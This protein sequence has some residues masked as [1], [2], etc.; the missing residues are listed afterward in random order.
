MTD[1]S[2]Y[3]RDKS[4]WTIKQAREDDPAYWSW[5]THTTSPDV[6]IKPF[7]DIELPAFGTIFMQPPEEAR[8]EAESLGIEPVYTVHIDGTLVLRCPGHD[9]VRYEGLELGYKA[10]SKISFDRNKPEHEELLYE[11]KHELPGGVI[12]RE[13]R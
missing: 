8:L 6:P 5:Y 13:Q 11:V 2:P 3:V 10:I 4:C 12:E 1:K 7:M 9:K